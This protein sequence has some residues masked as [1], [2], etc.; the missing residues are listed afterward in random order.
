MGVM[1]FIDAN[2]AI[3]KSMKNKNIDLCRWYLRVRVFCDSRK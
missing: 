3:V 1:Y 2:D